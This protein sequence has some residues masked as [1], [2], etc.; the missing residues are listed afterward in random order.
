MKTI[1]TYS[2]FTRETFMPVDDRRSIES[3]EQAQEVLTAIRRIIRAT[4]IHSK[5][6]RADTGLTAPQM[7][8]LKAI[9]MLGEVTAK[10]LAAHVSLSQATAAVILDRLEKRGLIER[11]RSPTDRRIVHSKLTKE[12]RKILR[13]T[14][15]LLQERF[16]ERF[17]ALSDTERG[18]LLASLQTVAEMMDAEHIDAAPVLTVSAPLAKH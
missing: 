18:V 3:D 5:H 6:L 7:V 11:Y 4:D 13:Q 16:V 2:D 1:E 10:A 8:V 9:D 14:P 15:R 12:G 17:A